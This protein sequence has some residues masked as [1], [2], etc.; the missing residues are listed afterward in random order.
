VIAL[1]V[2][3]ALAPTPPSETSVEAAAGIVRH[4]YAALAAHDYRSAYLLRRGGR[5]YPAFRQ[6]YAHTARTR[7]TLLPPFTTE[8]AAGS[9]YAKLN[10]RVD[11]RLT[12]G[13]RQGFLGSYTLRR[14]NDVDGSTPAQRR[15]HI[16]GATLRPVPVD[17]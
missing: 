12:N 8:G 14:V 2:A 11:A 7:V 4:Y 5:S 10:V 6:G 16:T 13:K 1:A 15:W 3:A 9:I 17:R